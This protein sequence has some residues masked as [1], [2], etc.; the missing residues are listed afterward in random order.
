MSSVSQIAQGYFLGRVYV[1]LF[2][3]LT[4]LFTPFWAVAFFIFFSF[5]YNP[6][7]SELK[8]YPPV[9]SSTIVQNTTSHLRYNFRVVL[10]TLV[11]VNKSVFKDL[12]PSQKKNF[13]S[14]ENALFK[15]KKWSRLIGRLS[16]QVPS[17][18]RQMEKTYRFF[19]DSI[20][21]LFKDK[22]ISKL[23]WNINK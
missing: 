8:N 10:A 12:T 9:L 1:A 13:P 3:F 11:P 15:S 21:S 4:I 22:P 14:T 20:W 5:T 19:M 18:Q 6:S 16:K 17:I 7:P 2:K 23:D